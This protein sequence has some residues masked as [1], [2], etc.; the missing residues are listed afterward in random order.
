MS[1]RALLI[2]AKAPEAGSV[3]TRLAGALDD[4][5][6][7]ALYLELL[8][9]TVAKMRKARDTELIINH[10][11][12]ERGDF[13]GSRYGLPLMAQRGEGIGLR[14]HN[15]ISDALGMGCDAVA[16]VGA[17]IPQLAPRIIER[18]F[19]L[20]AANDVVFGPAEDG[21][22][23]LVAMKGAHPGIFERVRWSSGHTLSDTLM[24]VRELGL[25]AALVDELYDIDRPEDLMRYRAGR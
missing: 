5:E 24:R 18:A 25:S 10:A 21:G 1:R 19:D 7:V 20:L 13:F 12:A 4:A 22:Y 14:M 17:D 2:M 6:R 16:L 3:K 11:P 9:A 15:A 23:Y 8:D